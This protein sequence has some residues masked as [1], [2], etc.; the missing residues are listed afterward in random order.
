MTNLALS[1]PGCNLAKG[2]RTMGLDRSGKVQS[3]FNP[4]DF[5]PGLLGWH[6][7][8]ILDRKNGLIIARTSIGEATVRTLRMNNPNRLIA[9]RIQIRVGLIG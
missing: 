2:G 6:L 1:C 3:L 9:R 4:R 8:F 5:D 7:H